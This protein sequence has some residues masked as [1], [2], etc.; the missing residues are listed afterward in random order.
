MT[1]LL[2]AR[3]GETDWNVDRRLQGHTNV[4]LNTAG[5][6]QARALAASLARVRLAAVYS[7]DL[8][9]ARDTAAAVAKAQGLDV[10]VDRD[11]RER[12]F[13]ALEGL[14]DA[15]LEARFPGAVGAALGRTETTAELASRVL[16]SIDRIRERHPA[17]PVLVVSHAG[18]LR[19]ILGHLAVEHGPIG[20]GDVFRVVY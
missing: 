9:R 11:L 7:S 19:A 4:P 16:A 6:E 10:T 17:R 1:E 15:E 13:G 5:L 18:P 14:T 2:L 12:S 8:A 20:N 3:H